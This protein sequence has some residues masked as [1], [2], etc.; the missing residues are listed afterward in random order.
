MWVFDR[1]VFAVFITML[2]CFVC[3]RCL[4]WWAVVVVGVRIYVCVRVPAAWWADSDP[5]AR[6]YANDLLNLMRTLL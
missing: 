1:C 6:P 4:V 2:T 5:A 3:A